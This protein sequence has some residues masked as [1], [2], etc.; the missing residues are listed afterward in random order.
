M[1]ADFETDYETTYY[2]SGTN[3]GRY[4]LANATEACISSKL[5]NRN[6]DDCGAARVLYGAGCGGR[7]ISAS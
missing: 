3:A 2:T 7:A 4:N 6:G 5:A 1:R